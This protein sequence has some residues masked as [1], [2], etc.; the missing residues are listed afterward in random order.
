MLPPIAADPE[1]LLLTMPGAPVAPPVCRRG[2]SGVV[3]TIRIVSQYSRV[4]GSPPPFRKILNSW[5]QVAL[6]FK[7]RLRSWPR[8]EGEFRMPLEKML[9]GQGGVSCYRRDRSECRY[10]S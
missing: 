2:G 9:K 3:K 6:S 4:S 8:L 10:L 7:E 5:Q 1:A